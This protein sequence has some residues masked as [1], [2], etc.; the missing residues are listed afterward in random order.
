[1]KRLDSI[2]EGKLQLEVIEC[3]CGYHNTLDYSY[4]DQVGDVSFPCPSCGAIIDSAVLCPEDTED[5]VQEHSHIEHGSPAEKLAW[6]K[7]KQN[8]RDTLK[9]IS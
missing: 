2:E 1:M 8:D 5:E 6:E 4:L 3:D 7:V 9:I